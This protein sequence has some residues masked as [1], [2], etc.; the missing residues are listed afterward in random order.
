M[1][2]LGAYKRTIH[3]SRPN[4]V[5]VP[6]PNKA[7]AFEIEVPLKERIKEKLKALS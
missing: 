6:D 4:D 5:N 3:V 7:P 2:N 1:A